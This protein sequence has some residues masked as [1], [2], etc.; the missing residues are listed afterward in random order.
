MS[1]EVLISYVSIVQQFQD[2][3]LDIWIDD[4]HDLTIWKKYLS[5]LWF[6]PPKQIGAY[7][8]EY[9]SPHIYH[10]GILI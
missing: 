4:I 5:T 6:I 9:L 2:E 7:G 10:L 1:L 8:V 3:I